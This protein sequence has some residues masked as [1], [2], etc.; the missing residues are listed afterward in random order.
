MKTTTKRTTV[1]EKS[2]QVPI[3]EIV[4]IIWI[5]EKKKQAKIAIGGKERIVKIKYDK[6]DVYP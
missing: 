4:S 6:T 5:D 3:D 1:S 2:I